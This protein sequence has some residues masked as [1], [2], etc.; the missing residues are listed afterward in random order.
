MWGDKGQRF[1]VVCAL[2]SGGEEGYNEDD[3]V[4]LAE[5][6]EGA[7]AATEAVSQVCTCVPTPNPGGACV[8]RRAQEGE[9]G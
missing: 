7:A 4:E 5:L 2:Q 8:R 9:D 6:R 3:D 1:A